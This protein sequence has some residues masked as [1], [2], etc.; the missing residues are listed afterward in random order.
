MLVSI[1]VQSSTGTQWITIEVNQLNRQD[2]LVAISRDA[3]ESIMQNDPRPPEVL[4]DLLCERVLK[5]M[6][7]PNGPDGIRLITLYNLAL[8]WPK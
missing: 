2:A 1:K 3:L 5:R 6:S 4:L 7:V 8:V